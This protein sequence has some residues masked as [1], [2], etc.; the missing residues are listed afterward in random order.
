MG[1]KNNIGSTRFPRYYEKFNIPSE[2]EIYEIDCKNKKEYPDIHKQ[3]FGPIEVK[4]S[5]SIKFFHGSQRD[6][7]VLRARQDDLHYRRYWVSRL[8]YDIYHPYWCPAC[9]IDIK[10]KPKH[11]L[12]KCFD[13]EIRTNALKIIKL[14]SYYYDDSDD[15]DGGEDDDHEWFYQRKDREHNP[16]HMPKKH[17]DR[18]GRYK[19]QR[20]NHSRRNLQKDFIKNAQEEYHPI[21]AYKQE[22]C[23]L[24][25]YQQ[26]WR[27]GFKDY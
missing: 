15:D 9:G 19:D 17:F 3:L 20:K 11:N 8:D 21:Y 27:K 14:E 6:L 16:K 13:E 4:E 25:N 5:K 12:E 24:Q 7:S 22:H 18:Q 23:T 10:N 2:G 1:R 26:H